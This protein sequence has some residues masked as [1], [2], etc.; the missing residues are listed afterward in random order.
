M[1]AFD[2]KKELGIGQKCYKGKHFLING[3]LDEI[4]KS[5]TLLINGDLDEKNK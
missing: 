3:E 1:K 5:N 4:K 2:W